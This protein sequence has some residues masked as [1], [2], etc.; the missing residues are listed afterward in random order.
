MVASHLPRHRIP[1]GSDS[2]TSASTISIQF[3]KSRLHSGCEALPLGP[4]SSV[5]ACEQYRV[6]IVHTVDLAPGGSVMDPGVHMNGE[7]GRRIAGRSGPTFDMGPRA[8]GLDR[9]AGLDAGEW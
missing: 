7:H 2:G 6:R 8:I 3:V 5:R 1:D 4:L 9:R